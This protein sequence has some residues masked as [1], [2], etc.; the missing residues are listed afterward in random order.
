MTKDIKIG[1]IGAGTMGKA[2]IKGLINTGFIDKQNIYVS[3]ATPEFAELASKDLGLAVTCDNKKLAQSSDFIVLCVKPFYMK[4]VITEIKE[5]LAENKVLISI[6]A[7]ITTESIEKT[8]QI[9]VPVVR[10]MPNTP[11]LVGEGMSAVA[12]GK[13]AK[14]EHAEFVIEMFSK[15]GKCIE[16]K[17]K[18]LNAVTGISG[19]GPAFAYLIIDALA[20][21]GVKQGLTKHDALILAAQTLIGAGKMVLETG[22]HPSVLKDEVT[23]PGGTT[24]EGLN[25]LENEGVVPALMKAVEKTAEKAEKLSL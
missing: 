10:V 17:E 2:I 21:G 23:T 12:K 8:A 6:A 22:K 13:Y 11:V 18:A 4:E 16:V 19:S 15:T 25:V 20:D 1:F 3:E 24:I 7:G 14:K 5:E 9:N